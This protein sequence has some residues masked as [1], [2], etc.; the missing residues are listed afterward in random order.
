M[1]NDIIG[2]G[3]NYAPALSVI[4]KKIKKYIEYNSWYFIQI[5]AN[6][7]IILKVIHTIMKK[8]KFSGLLIEAIT[9]YML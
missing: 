9:D 2:N 6:N 8:E 1:I 5:D 3:I 4:Y 7:M